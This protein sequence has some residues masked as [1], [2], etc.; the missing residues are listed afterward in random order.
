MVHVTDLGED[1]LVREE[2]LGWERALKDKK[3]LK[4]ELRREKG[5]EQGARM[6]QCQQNPEM[7]AFKW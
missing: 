2:E 3:R 1:N 7:M 4:E 5:K 6:A